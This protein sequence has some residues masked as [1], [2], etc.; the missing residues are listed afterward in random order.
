MHDRGGGHG[1]QREDHRRANDRRGGHPQHVDQHRYQQKS[2]ADAHNGSDKADDKPDAPDRDRG[3]VDARALEPQL[4]RQ[5]VDPGMTAGLA[6][7]DGLTLS[8]ANDGA[9]ALGHHQ[10]SYDAEKENVRNTD[11][12]IE[13]AKRAEHREEPDAESGADD[14]ASEQHESEREIDGPP[15]PIADRAGHGR[16]GDV[17]SDACHG[18]R[19]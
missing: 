16:R 17:G 7:L 19:R 11:S 15:M 8:R 2:A 4:E 5:S 12:D 6:Q 14:A 3:D 1:H 18:D 9:Y 10:G 13:L